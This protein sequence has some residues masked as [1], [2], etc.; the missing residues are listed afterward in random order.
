MIAILFLLMLLAVGIGL[1]LSGHSIARLPIGE[2]LALVGLFL[3]FFGSGVYIGAALGI[4]GLIAGFAFSDR[5]FWLFIG[6]TIWS[7]S[8]SFI[9]IAVPLF[10]LMGEILLRAGLSDRLYRALNLWLNRLPGGLLHTNIVASGVF[11]AVSGSSIATAAT[12]GSVALPFFRSTAYD[13]RYVMGSLAAGGAL[14][15]LIPP[16]IT[17]IIY[18]LIT[19]TSVGALYIAA[20]GPGLLVLLAFVAVI[21]IHGLRHPLPIG[22][23]VPLAAKLRG[24]VD[25]LPTLTLIAIVLGTIY[26]G[27]ATPTESAALGVVA[28][29]VL[30]A[31]DRRLSWSMLNVASEISGTQHGADRPDPVRSVPPELCSHQPRRAAGD[32]Q[33]G[34]RPPPATMGDHAADHRILPGA[35][36]LHGRVFHGDHYDPGDLSGC[37][38]AG[39]RSRVVRRDH[40]HAG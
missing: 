24:L 14:G 3:V 37:E 33:L 39:L 6:Q 5:P 9:L 15:N 10:L 12:M 25:L 29:I 28:A 35:R 21:F 32:G 2:I 18:G 7:P 31:I 27:L 4:L 38:S 40:H 30:A 36:H 20:L 34:R 22:P 1:S 11:S 26:G 13:R 16:G 23:V 19:E 17:F 8:S